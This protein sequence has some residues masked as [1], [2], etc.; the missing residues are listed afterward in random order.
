MPSAG[1]LATETPLGPLQSGLLRDAPDSAS[2]GQGYQLGRGALAGAKDGTKGLGCLFGSFQGSDA[3]GAFGGRHGR[4]P[5][6]VAGESLMVTGDG[7]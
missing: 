6:A 4:A 5:E 2:H 1:D 3:G 7:W